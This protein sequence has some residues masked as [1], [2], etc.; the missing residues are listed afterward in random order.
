[1]TLPAVSPNDK[2]GPHPS[3]AQQGEELAPLAPVTERLA[4][5]RRDEELL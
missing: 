2:P 3:V 5:E 4:M 1:M